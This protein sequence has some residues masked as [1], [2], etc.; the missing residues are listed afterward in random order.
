MCTPK[1]KAFS[2]FSRGVYTIIVFF[3]KPVTTYPAFFLNIIIIMI[4]PSLLN[5]YIFNPEAYLHYT[6]T[7]LL[8]FFVKDGMSF[9]F[10]L[11]IPT[12]VSYVV[13]TLLLLFKYYMRRLL[14][15]SIFSVYIC[16]GVLYVINIF[17]QYIMFS[18]F[19]NYFL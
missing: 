15:V 1:N 11:F 16:L 8:G 7:R 4:I 5:A 19:L 9:P 12:F 14:C 13:C 6:S 18:N 3:L 17:F 10:I 2:M